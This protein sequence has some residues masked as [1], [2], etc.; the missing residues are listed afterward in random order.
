MVGARG[1]EPPTP[2]SRTRCATRLRYAPNVMLSG[3]RCSLNATRGP[4]EGSLNRSTDTRS[5]ADIRGVLREVA[6]NS[7]DTEEKQAWVE[8]CGVTRSRI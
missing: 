6:D 8:H 3:Y 4:R 5:L 1:F 7:K 2:W